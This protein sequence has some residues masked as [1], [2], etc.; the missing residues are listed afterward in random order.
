MTDF[1]FE[2]DIVDPLDVYGP[3]IKCYFGIL[4]RMIYFFMIASVLLIPVLY[5]NSQG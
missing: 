2:E 5:F 4:R 1:I 3:G